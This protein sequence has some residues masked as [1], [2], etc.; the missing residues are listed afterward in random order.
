[1][2]RITRRTVQA[3]E[4]L[5]PAG[6]EEERNADLS[7]INDQ[8][9]PTNGK[10]ADE[11]QEGPTPTDNEEERNGVSLD[12]QKTPNSQDTTNDEN[13]A[14]VSSTASSQLTNWIGY[15]G[16][17]STAFPND[18]KQ[19]LS[20]N[21]ANTIPSS[22]PSSLLSSGSTALAEAK[23]G[24]AVLGGERKEAVESSEKVVEKIDAA[25]KGAKPQSGRDTAAMKILK[26][27]IN[28]PI[29]DTVSN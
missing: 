2:F 15:G 16:V 21:G 27:V 14:V 22:L 8:N 13:Q 5:T 9:T 29:G 3:Q 20:D 23:G 18:N 24:H 19:D 4:G 25:E 1:M 17:G 10:K 12:D 7:P 11:A 28:M 26:S 6:N